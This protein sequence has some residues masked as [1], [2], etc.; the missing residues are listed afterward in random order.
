MNNITNALLDKNA[1]LSSL[2]A[3]VISFLTAVLA[4]VNDLAD[5]QTIANISSTFWFTLFIG[6]I[7]TVLK[8]AHARSSVPPPQK[9]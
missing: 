6:L 3:A 7:L 2:I 4:R 9:V 1:L 5:G 8:D